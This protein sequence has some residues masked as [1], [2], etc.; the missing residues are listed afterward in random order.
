MPNPRITFRLEPEIMNQLPTDSDERSQWFKD[1]VLQKLNPPEP[2]DE[3]G[4]VKRQLANLETVV[5]AMKRHF[6]S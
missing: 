6:P 5:Q 3:L 2:E 1:A 4:Q